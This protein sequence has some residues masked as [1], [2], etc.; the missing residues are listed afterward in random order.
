MGPAGTAARGCGGS[1][2][3]EFINLKL[4]KTG[5]NKKLK[6]GRFSILLIESMVFTELI[7]GLISS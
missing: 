5:I 3:F 7:K 1:L 6:R 2:R 4:I